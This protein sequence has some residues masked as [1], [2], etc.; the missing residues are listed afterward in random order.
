MPGHEFVR[1]Y[2]ICKCIVFVLLYLK[3]ARHFR[4]WQ[5]RKKALRRI[6]KFS[7]PNG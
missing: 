7:V 5:F 4:K 6:K 1:K 2:F 3:D